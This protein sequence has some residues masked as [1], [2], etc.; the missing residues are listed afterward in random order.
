MPKVS[1]SNVASPYGIDLSALAPNLD[2]PLH[3]V[4]AWKETVYEV[5]EGSGG[6]AKA[7][8]GAY[9]V[10]EKHCANS[11]GTGFR[12]GAASLSLWMSGDDSQRMEGVF[13]KPK[14]QAINSGLKVGIMLHHAPHRSRSALRFA[15]QPPRS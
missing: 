14:Q 3:V 1:L 15:T 4:D 10:S 12:K 9:E 2:P 5:P 8:P 6:A 13:C 7:M 11:V